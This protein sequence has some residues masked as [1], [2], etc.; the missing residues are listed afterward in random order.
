MQNK[1]GFDADLIWGNG[2]DETLGDDISVTIIATGFSTS[3]IPKITGNKPVEKEIH[4][5][6][7]NSIAAE[8]PQMMKPM[9]KKPPVVTNQKTIEFEIT[10][11][12]KEEIS[13]DPEFESLYPKTVQER[14]KSEEKT[15][16]TDLSTMSDEDVDEM[17]NVPAY[18]RRQLRMNDPRYTNK[19]S[20]F[21][22]TKENRITN[23]NSYLHG[24]VD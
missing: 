12:K 17:E 11:D 15:V 8:T 24:Q 3:S 2:K 9:E 22:V 4:V 19:T 23:K 14:H 18:K 13:E 20:N 1:A 16:T 7:E 10:K 6:S 21:S 5:F